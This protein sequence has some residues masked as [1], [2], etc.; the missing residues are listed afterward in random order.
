MTK[1]IEALII[2]DEIK[3]YFKEGFSQ[4]HITTI[5]DPLFHGN[6]FHGCVTSEGKEYKVMIVPVEIRGSTP[7]ETEK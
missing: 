1:V 6:W 5:L 3:D 2:Y 7:K 4:S